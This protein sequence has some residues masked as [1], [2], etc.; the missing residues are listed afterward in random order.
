LLEGLVRSGADA[1]VREA[2]ASALVRAGF[3]LLEMSPVGM[4]LEDIFLKL[5]T[6]E[7]EAAREVKAG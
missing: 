3:G 6:E 4:S 5:T 1:E 2:V 7:P